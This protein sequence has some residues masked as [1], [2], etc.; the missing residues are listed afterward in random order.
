MNF[1][2]IVFGILLLLGLYN[3]YKKGLFVEVA[4]LVGL[5]AGVIGAVHFSYFTAEKLMEYVDWSERLIN[6]ASFAITFSL[7]VVAIAFAGKMLTKIADFTALGI[8]NKILGAV[9]GMLKVAFVLSVILWFTNQWGKSL[10]FFTEDKIE[11]SILFEPIEMLAPLVLPE[12]IK[13]AKEYIPEK[14]ESEDES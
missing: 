3:G 8:F 4:S 2:D 7:I 5:V 9:F 11:E 14:A 1:I 13:E 10:L 6:L 12:I